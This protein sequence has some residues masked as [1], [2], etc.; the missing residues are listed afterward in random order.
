MLY[1][2]AKYR[3]SIILCRRLL[4]NSDGVPS[5]AQDIASLIVHTKDSFGVD[6]IVL[7]RAGV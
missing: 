6:A 4:A 7:R 1:T 3:T 5:V 2:K